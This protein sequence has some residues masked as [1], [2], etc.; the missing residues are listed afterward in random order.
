MALLLANSYLSFTLTLTLILILTVN[1]NLTLDPNP[2]SHPNPNL[3]PRL[4]TLILSL[5]LTLTLGPN[6]DSH[7]KVSL[8]MRIMNEAAAATPSEE[9]EPGEIAT[10]HDAMETDDG[11][12]VVVAG[13]DPTEQRRVVVTP[14]VK[15]R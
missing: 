15:E 1:P 12:G 13:E 11:Y 7:P 14:M 8:S 6:P 9:H 5:T 10:D 4:P 3:D 2:H